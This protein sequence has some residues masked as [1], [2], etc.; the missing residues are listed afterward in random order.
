MLDLNQ[1]A[2]DDDKRALELLNLEVK[3][4]KIEPSVLM[5]QT[6]LSV[7]NEFLPILE[8]IAQSL[9]KLSQNFGVDESEE[10]NDN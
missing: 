6:L 1:N 7:A 3:N 4:K 5:A 2:V 10:K 9:E 8:S